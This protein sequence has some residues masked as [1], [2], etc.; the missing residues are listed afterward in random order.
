[1]SR[2]GKLSNV[3]SYLKKI[4]GFL[5]AKESNERIIQGGWKTIGPELIRLSEIPDYAGKTRNDY[6]KLINL[7]SEK[8]S[9]KGE[10]LPFKKKARPTRFPQREHSKQQTKDQYF[11]FYDSYDWKVL[12]Y[13]IIK[14]Y[15]TRCMCCKSDN[16]PP[17]VDH[18]KPLRY[19]WDLRLD[20]NNLQ[21]LCPSCNRGKS[22]TDETDWRPE[23]KNI[24]ASL[25][26]FSM[27][28]LIL[29]N[30]AIEEIHPDNRGRVLIIPSEELQARRAKA[31][32]KIKDILGTSI[33]HLKQWD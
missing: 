12:R 29:I 3:K 5:R 21:I 18:I 30:Q 4:I 33:D 25:K 32:E 24:K 6:I 16:F 20:P 28:T 2:K 31:I 23:S 11:D 1:L 17:H 7:I 26:E 8:Y 22:N 19:N 9:L 13:S 10:K 27:N 15:G 14:R